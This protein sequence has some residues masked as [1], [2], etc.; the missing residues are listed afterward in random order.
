MG[1]GG[2]ASAAAPGN[3]NGVSGSPEMPS[4]TAIPTETDAVMANTMTATECGPAQPSGETAPSSE[5]VLMDPT[6]VEGPV[7]LRRGRVCD[8]AKL[9]ESISFSHTRRHRLSR[10]IKPEAD[11]RHSTCRTNTVR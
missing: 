5:K 4:D 11:P 6:F 2:A 9:H 7:E 1:I 3:G 10:F 8:H